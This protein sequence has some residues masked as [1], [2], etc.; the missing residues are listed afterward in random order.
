[1]R[2][3]STRGRNAADR[4]PQRRKQ[5]HIVAVPG[6]A[7]SSRRVARVWTDPPS[8]STRWSLS[9]A[10]KP[11]D[12]L[13]G[14]Q[15]GASAPSVPATARANRIPGNAATIVTG[16]RTWRRT[17][18][19]GRRARWPATT[20]PRLAA[21]RSRRASRRR[22]D[23]ARQSIS[24]A[25]TASVS[26]ASAPIHASRSRRAVRAEAERRWPPGRPCERIVDLEPRVADVAEPSVAIL[27]EAARSSRRIDGGV[28]RQRRQVGLARQDRGENVGHVVA[29]KRGPPGQHF[30][31]HAA[32]RPDVGALVDGLAARLLGAHVGGG[33]ED[34]ARVRHAPGR[35]GRRLRRSRRR[36][37]TRL[38]RLGQAEVEH[39]DRAVRPDLDVG[40][41]QIAVDDA[42]LV[43][44]FER[45][46]ICR[47]IGSAS[48]SGSGR[49]RSG[50]RGRRPRR[51][52]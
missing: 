11:T 40:R 32:E 42:L 22:R 51:A 46:A 25:A 50:R 21:C 33:A 26:A 34:H 1:M 6:A 19:S 5:D 4:I 36:A 48:S 30:V 12:R 29:G 9:S 49:A 28:R 18:W 35:D 7:P 8:T 10:K 39:L 13:S 38:Q 31:E 41:L 52:P 44:G 20:A 45:S 2:R 43:R 15:N 3:V 37:S 17:Q 14:D 24:D 23:G 47:A 27:L 16:L